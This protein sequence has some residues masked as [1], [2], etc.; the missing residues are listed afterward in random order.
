M[1]A[2]E[3]ARHRIPVRIVDKSPGIDPHVRANLIHSRTLEIFQSLGIA[4]QVIAGGLE[5]LGTRVYVRGELVGDSRHAPIASPF[6]YGVSQS[7]AKTEAV[8]E[9][10][11]N[12]LG[13]TVERSV[14]L[15]RL[16]QD[17]SRVVA[18]VEHADRREEVVEA[19][20][21]IG[22]DGAHSTVRHLTGCAFPGD[23]DPYCYL[24]G[25]VKLEGGLRN[26]EVHLF[27]HDEGEY[28]VFTAHSEDHRLV[29]ANVE[30]DRD[31]A[32]PTTVE[33]L[34]EL[35]ERRGFPGLRISDPKWL[36]Q[37]RI[38]YRLAP[39][40]RQGRVFLAGDAAHIHS[41]FAGQ[42][43]NMGIQDAHN[44]AWKLALVMRGLAPEWWLDT[45]ES[46]R[47]KVAEGVVEMT[48]AATE[49]CELYANVSEAERERIV[50][51]L[52]VPEAERLKAAEHLQQ[53]DLDYRGSPLCLDAENGFQ[54]GPHP[55][56]EAPTTSPLLVDGSPRTL[57]QIL[58]GTNHRLL[59]F[60]GRV[61]ETRPDDIS[62]AA[63]EVLDRH[64]H[65]I[66]IFLVAT[67]PLAVSG[68]PPEVC[69]IADPKRAL[70]EK[71]GVHQPSLY[72]IR[73]DGHVA[74]R[75]PKPNGL[76]RYLEH[77]LWTARGMR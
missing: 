35:A 20:W 66:D 43:M 73:P 9:A 57:F 60:S 72:L 39:H 4:E 3:L 75:D 46:E 44:L 77:A 13:V 70:H 11:L 59:L 52:F 29:A 71:Y 30:V 51:R 16:V 17:D 68:L 22:C 10:H 38:R 74:Y 62:K 40:Y 69:V 53:V 15:K 1:M 63:K 7:Q 28:A 26:D 47:R 8:L 2:A 33:E 12:R 49:T 54:G 21:A 64:G 27:L 5:E 48:R 23:R 6:P 61:S 14:R 55:G 45:Y 36:T 76:Q 58:S 32:E 67:E 24:L 31:P 50:A 18:T 34:Q 25:D 19:P 56:A 41:P 37:F 65:W 42:G